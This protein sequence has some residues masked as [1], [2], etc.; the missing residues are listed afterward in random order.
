MGSP[1]DEPERSS[2]EW[3]HEVTLTNGF[4]LAE[5]ACAQELWEAVMGA[6]PSRF[7]GA[8]RPVDSVSWD[9]CME[10]IEKINAMIPGLDLRLPTEAE[11]EYSCRAG[12]TTPFSFGDNITTDQVNYDGNNPYHNGAKGQYRKKTVDTKFFPCNDWGL[13]EM[14]GNVRDWCSDYWNEAYPEGKVVDPMGPDSGE[15]RVMRG[16][17][18]YHDG[19]DVRSA[20]RHWYEPG[21]RWPS[22]GFRLARGHKSQGV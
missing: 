18:W 21:N 1:E 22:N 8:K 17:G 13:Y 5:T 14:H 19:R 3:L 9:D 20:Y 4:W 2:G 10:F 12:T 6:N 16:G 7:K 11:W 15:S